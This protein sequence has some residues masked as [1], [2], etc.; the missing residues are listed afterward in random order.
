MGCKVLSEM[1]PGRYKTGMP[2]S[3]QIKSTGADDRGVDIFAGA[4]FS[5]TAIQD[6][7]TFEHCP[8]FV[9]NN[10]KLLLPQNS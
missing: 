7:Q 3:V 5:M 8:A 6:C 4:G 10:D 2:R 1:P 9:I